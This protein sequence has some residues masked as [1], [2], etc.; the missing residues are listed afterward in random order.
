MNSLVAYLASEERTTASVIYNV[1]FD[2]GQLATLFSG[3]YPRWE[4]PGSPKLCF[5]RSP[6]QKIN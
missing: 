1:E 5:V 2:A 4:G 6:S 3:T